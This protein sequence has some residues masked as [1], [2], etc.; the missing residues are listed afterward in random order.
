VDLLI[1]DDADEIRKIAG[2]INEINLQRREL[3]QEIVENALKIIDNDEELKKRKTTVLWDAGWH[4]GVIGI[5]ASRLIETYYRPTILLTESE[6]VLVGSARSVFGFDLYQAISQ[7]SEYLDR[8]GGHQFAAGLSMKKE[9]FEAFS[10]KFEEVVSSTILEECLTPSI[11]YDIEMPLEFVN[12]KII[13][14]IDRLGP[15]GP[16]NMKPR[17]VSKGLKL[18]ETARVV[19][20][21]HLKLAIQSDKKLTFNAI[22]FKQAY[23]LEALNNGKA[24]DICYTLEINEWNSYKNV[25]LNIK[26][27][28]VSS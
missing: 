11:L 15:F 12:M 25:Q 28:K 21:D 3:D 24:F 14:T 19:G 1:K 9:N 13:N 16:S 6:G 4:K 22:A 5:V 8:F 18:A 27:I 26:D 20:K 7:C 2:E 17:F 23:Q 10:K